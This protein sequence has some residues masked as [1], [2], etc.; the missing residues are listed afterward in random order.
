M[1]ETLELKA[2]LGSLLDH[3]IERGHGGLYQHPSCQACL[4]VKRAYSLLGVEYE[5]VEQLATVATFATA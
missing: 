4:D 5:H 2:A 1:D 3:M